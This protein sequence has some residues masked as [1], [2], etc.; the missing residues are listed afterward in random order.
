MAVIALRRDI[1]VTELACCR[2]DLFSASSRARPMRSVRSTP[3][4][5]IENSVSFVPTRF[6]RPAEISGPNCAKAIG[7][8][9]KGFTRSNR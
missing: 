3:L 4:P 7:K 5:A 6:S 9:R 2:S 1:E 8:C